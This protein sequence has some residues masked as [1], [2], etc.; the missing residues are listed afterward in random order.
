MKFLGLNNIKKKKMSS[1]PP[2]LPP[3]PKSSLTPKQITIS[4]EHSVLLT[5]SKEELEDLLNN[6]IVFESFLET[7]EP[8]RGMNALQNEVMLNNKLHAEKTL[9][10][11][12][13]LIQLQQKV[14][15]KEK[16]FKELYSTLQE[17][18]Q[19][20]QESLQRFSP[21]VLLTK[22]KSEVHQSD[23]L[24]E[25]MAASFLLDKLECDQ[26]LKHYK[27]IRK[28]YHMRNAKAERA[29]K[30]PEILGLVN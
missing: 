18:N 19:I 17:K 27:E 8:L 13:E 9:S 22:L 25:Q 30:K 26:F 6:D 28:V 21:S 7:V 1:T 16:E 20:Q 23:E 10:Q 12:Q 15:S 3:L 2:P 5:K 29:S 11:E 24:S 14:E 4:E